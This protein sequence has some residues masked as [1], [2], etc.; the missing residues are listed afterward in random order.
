ML[1][2][3]DTGNLFTLFFL[4]S[5][6][7]IDCAFTVSSKD[8]KFAVFLAALRFTWQLAGEVWIAFANCLR[9]VLIGFRGMHLG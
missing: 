8:P 7:Q 1:Q 5:I 9:E 2:L 3:A 4:I 6:L